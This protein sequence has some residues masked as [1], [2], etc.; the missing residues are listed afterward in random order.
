MTLHRSV[1]CKMKCDVWAV[2]V[3]H[4]KSIGQGGGQVTP[5]HWI[6]DWSCWTSMIDDFCFGGLLPLS[7]WSLLWVW[8]TGSCHLAPQDH[9]CAVGD[10]GDAPQTWAISVRMTKKQTEILCKTPATVQ[11]IQQTIAFQIHVWEIMQKAL[12][13]LWLAWFTFHPHFSWIKLLKTFLQTISC[14]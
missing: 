12:F 2:F 5:T 8:V 13:S 6:N 1:R 11:F 4:K 3:T 7:L 10:K 9:R 14:F